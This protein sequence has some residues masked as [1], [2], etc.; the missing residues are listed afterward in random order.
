MLNV[1]KMGPPWIS[2]VTVVKL[3]QFGYVLKLDR[4]VTI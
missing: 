2:K 3:V 4:F 1:N